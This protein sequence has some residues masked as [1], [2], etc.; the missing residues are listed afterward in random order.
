MVLVEVVHNEN[1]GHYHAISVF[2]SAVV[3]CLVMFLDW[4]TAALFTIRVL[5]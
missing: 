5:G 3:M 1:G 4:C 2:V